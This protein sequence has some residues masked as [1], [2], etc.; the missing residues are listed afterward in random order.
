MCAIAAI[1]YRVILRCIPYKSV[2]K[3]KTKSK[4][5]FRSKAKNDERGY[6]FTHYKLLISFKNITGQ[7]E[8]SFEQYCRENKNI[9][10]FCSCLG[11][12]DFEIDMDTNGPDEFRE[13]L[14]EMKI[15]FSEIIKDYNVMIVHRTNK[16]NFC[17]SMP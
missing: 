10:Y 16:Y 3:Q 6:P 8:K 13:N 5:L 15:E 1:G 2:E 9:W 14:R 7:K 4:A 11:H 17:P 12:W